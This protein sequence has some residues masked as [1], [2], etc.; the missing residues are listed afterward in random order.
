MFLIWI[1]AYNK[2]DVDSNHADK[3]LKWLQSKDMQKKISH[4]KINMQNA[5]QIWKNYWE[6]IKLSLKFLVWCHKL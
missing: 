5:E 3:T 1:L 4:F 2:Q 6:V